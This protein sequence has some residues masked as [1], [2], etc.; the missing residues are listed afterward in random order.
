M[1]GR[2]RFSFIRC[3]FVLAVLGIAG[4]AGTPSDFN[5]VVLRPS[6]TQIAAGAKVTITASVPKDTMN[7]G[8]TWVLTPGPGAPMP[9][10]TFLSTNQQATF[11]APVTVAASYYVTI[12]ATSV[13]FPT[14]MSSVKITIQ[15]PKPLKITTTSLPNG[16]LGVPYTTTT[17]QATGGVLPYTWSLAAGSGPL[18][19]GLMLAPNGTIS[20]TPTGVTT[21][22]F[23]IT[24][25]VADSEVP[26]MMKTASLSITITNLLSGNYAF[27]FNGF[28]AQ[29]AII[30][31][32]N[33]TSD[34]VSK[35]SG[36]V[37]DFNAITG[38][39]SGGTLETFT[40]TYPI[41]T[42]GRGTLTLTTSKWHSHLRVRARL[43][44]IAR[45]PRGTR[46]EWQSRLW[47]N[48]AAERD[49]LRFEHAFRRGSAWRRFRHRNYRH[50][51]WFRRNTIWAIRPCWPLHCEIP[52][53]LVHAGNDRQRR[54]G[55]QR[56]QQRATLSCPT[57]PSRALSRRP[58]NH[59]AAP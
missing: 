29:G 18:P 33:F 27:E 43:K 28:N 50:G 32:G 46:F 5:T 38:T 23:P 24:V 19:A 1:R 34:G 30:A 17:L 31:A 42:L 12:T 14:E 10:G 59:R 13:A 54:S 9:P 44:R 53:D 21:G 11:T 40:G 52:G 6:A 22:P 57:Q 7:E 20:G 2:A 26:P 45:P 51:G 58:R 56:S 4:C 25:Q 35:I 41:D 49:N 39:P 48:R 36:G 47:R 16:T 8:V 3:L 55:R 37:G 15:P